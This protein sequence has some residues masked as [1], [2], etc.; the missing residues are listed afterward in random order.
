MVEDQKS[1]INENET[2]QKNEV[3]TAL[4]EGIVKEMRK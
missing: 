4:K 2:K 1:V 3:S